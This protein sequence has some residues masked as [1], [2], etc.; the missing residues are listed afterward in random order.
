MGN[1]NIKDVEVIVTREIPKRPR[2]GFGLPLILATNLEKPYKEYEE[3]EEVKKDFPESTEAYKIA[4]RIFNQK[5]KPDIVAMVGLEYDENTPGDLIVFLDEL[6]EVNNDWY[7]FMSDLQKDDEITALSQYFDETSKLYFASTSNKELVKTLESD[8]TIVMYHNEPEQYPAEGWVGVGATEEAGSITWKFKTIEGI[9]AAD[10]KSAELI[11]LHK[12]G[13]NSYVQKL[14]VLQ[15]SDG[16]T[17][18]GEYIDVMCSQHFL[19]SELN[20]RVSLLFMNNKKIEYENSGIALIVAECES[21]MKQAT[22]QG[23]VK[24]DSDGNGLWTVAAPKREDIPDYEAATRHLD[25]VVIEF[26]I[27]GAVHS[28]T[29][30]VTMKY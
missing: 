3:L 9:S 22:T 20:R 18:S 1:V 28:A 12:D 19:E 13:G 11:Q 15:S 30:R 2:K 10:I 26:K 4:T 14:G 17:T 21:V 8:N 25:G 27:S 24:K 6:A 23:I 7:Y 5:P 16:I 29:I